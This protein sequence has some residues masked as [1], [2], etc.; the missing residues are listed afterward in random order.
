MKH[1]EKTKQL[2]AAIEEIRTKAPYYDETKHWFVYA[3][4]G[5]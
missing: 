3:L 1:D 4:C 2:R 5:S